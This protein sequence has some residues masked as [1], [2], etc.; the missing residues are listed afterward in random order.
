MKTKSQIVNELKTAYPVLQKGDDV[1][2]YVEL[3]E[4][5]YEATIELWADNEL[6]RLSLEADILAKAQAKIEL[7][8]RLG[9]TEDEAKLLLA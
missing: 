8:E 1:V 9:I 5:E 2:G 6:A 4:T 3:T 7:L